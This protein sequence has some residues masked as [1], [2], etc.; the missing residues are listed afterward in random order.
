M[1][2]YSELCSLLILASG[3]QTY[4]LYVQTVLGE[5]CCYY[6]FI[7]LGVRERLLIEDKL[8]QCEGEVGVLRSR[9]SELEGTLAEM[10]SDKVAVAEDNQQLRQEKLQVATTVEQSM[11]RA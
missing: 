6:A 2:G 1:C 5:K 4:I 3:T 11:W 10:E 9:C 8:C 7:R